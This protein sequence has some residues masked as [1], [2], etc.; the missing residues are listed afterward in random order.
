M[1]PSVSHAARL[2]PRFRFEAGSYGGGGRPYA[3][4]AVCYEQIAQDDWRE[5]FCLANPTQLFDTADEATA[6]T[7][8]DLQ[9]AAARKAAGGT[10]ADFAMTLKKKGYLAVDNFQR[11]RD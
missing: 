9:E 5:H 11:A 7:E 6:Q 1:A 8:T 4:S 10:D 2:S 3:P